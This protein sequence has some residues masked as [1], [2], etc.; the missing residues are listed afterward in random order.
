M[1]LEVSGGVYWMLRGACRVAA[2]LRQPEIGSDSILISLM[3]HFPAFRKVFGNAFP[4][5]REGGGAR[6]TQNGGPIALSADDELQLLRVMREVHWQVFG[7]EPAE[8]SPQWAEEAHEAVRRAMVVAVVQSGPWVGPDHLLES[9]LGDSGNAASHLVERQRVDLELL[10]EVARRTWPDPGGEPP[11]RGM[12]D[13]LSRA[14]VLTDSGR[15][16]GRQSVSMAQRL[17]SGVFRV[18]A[19]TSPVLA[20]LEDEAIAETVR[21]GHDRTTATHLI[22]AVLLFEEELADSGLRPVP[23]YEPSCE[24]VLSSFGLDRRS[25]SATAASDAQ[26]GEIA[27]PQRR[28]SWRSS[29]KN[30]PWTLTAA[31]M[32]DSAR[33]MARAGQGLPAGSAHLLYAVLSDPD[34]AG[35]S[36]LREHGADPTEVVA[37]LARRLQITSSPT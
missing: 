26:V 9:L 32:A 23:Q 15:G 16:R 18:V 10:T 2:E 28:R 14:G 24:V 8:G 7:W 29:P 1:S 3:N 20:F 21:M 11:R 5:V 13:V 36:L 19:Q 4:Q 6:V 31:R 22:L 37:R 27:P 35:R 30:P 12:V 34:D 25:L 33:T 17:A